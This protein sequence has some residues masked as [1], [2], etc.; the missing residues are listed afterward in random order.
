MSLHGL[1]TSLKIKNNQS[2]VEYK[3]GASEIALHP[4]SCDS[5]P[6]SSCWLIEARNDGDLCHCGNGESRRT[7]CTLV[8]LLRACKVWDLCT[9]VPK[10]VDKMLKQVGT[11]IA[12]QIVY[13]SCHRC[14]WVCPMC[15]PG[16]W[17]IPGGRYTPHTYTPA[18]PSLSPSQTSGA[19]LYVPWCLDVF[20]RSI[21]YRSSQDLNPST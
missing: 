18:H 3:Y 13:S 14:Y 9:F 17:Q 8:Y 20:H 7:P 10:F 1:R 2:V 19:Y 15:V 21:F 11:E 6:N 5:H 4:R 12:L 16:R